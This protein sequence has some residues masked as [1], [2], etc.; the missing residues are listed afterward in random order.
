MEYTV[1]L[2]VLPLLL[3]FLSMIFKAQKKP[4]LYG[5]A[6]LNVALLFII[7]KG[8]YMIGGFDA[9]YGINLVLDQ[10]SFI[11]VVLIN[12]MFF[13]S[14]I[15][16]KKLIGEHS[17]ILLTLLAGVNGM[18]LTG[19]LFNLFV[20]IEIT[21]ISAYIMTIQSKKY[22]HTFNYLIVGSVGSGLYL[23]GVILLYA[24]FGSLN[25]AHI[26][27][28]INNPGTQLL[29]PFLLIFVALS[30]E[31][32]LF[33][34]NGW[35]KGVYKNANGL[36]G[37]LMVSIVASAGLFVMG[38]IF[39]TL[40]LTSQFL[41]NT[42]LVVA[43]ITLISGEFSAFKGQSIKEILLYSSIGQ[44]GLVTILLA[45]G[46]AFPAVLVLINNAISKLV[47]F[48][49]ADELN[50]KS[51]NS[52]LP[53]DAPYATLKGHFLQHKILGLGFTIASFS[54]IGLPL[55]LGFYAKLNSL[56]GLFNVHMLLPA[57]IL[58]VTIVEGAY[59]IKLNISLW[60]PGQEGESV[61]EMA[62]V[63]TENNTGMILTVVILSAVIVISG[64]KPDL[65]GQQILGGYS[66]NSPE[67]VYLIDL[68][69]GH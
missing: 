32:K 16:N 51:S 60:H 61:Y 45:S 41:M 10:W 26:A 44:S 46:L 2:I 4:L 42:I 12:T 28:Q 59:L 19:D 7:Q 5:G 38:R 6:T 31:T 43:V 55:F 63:Q 56:I 68:K 67:T 64:L 34:F 53:E 13:L 27:G 35:V 49:I 54:L 30:V 40:L 9:P 29:L 39:G 52:D 25:I 24:A 8:E 15:S 20:F 36:V 37:S 14:L 48:S 3:S 17:P 65:L 33:P 66:D 23:L 57:V 11:A 62:P 22:I 1:L 50:A 58:L 69:G 21:T 47:M 18:V